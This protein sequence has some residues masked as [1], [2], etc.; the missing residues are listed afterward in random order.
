MT[1]DICFTIKLNLN[2]TIGLL[3]DITNLKNLSSLKIFWLQNC[4]T[5]FKR[6]LHP[7]LV[8]GSVYWIQLM[9]HAKAK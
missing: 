2:V 1:N 7:V 9:I 4:F 8:F 3:N 5:E 6:I